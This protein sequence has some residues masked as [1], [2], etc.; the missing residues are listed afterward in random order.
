MIGESVVLSETFDIPG[1]VLEHR[2][3]LT[4][5]NDLI[6]GVATDPSDPD[7]LHMYF[8]TYMLHSAPLAINIYSNI[9][10]KRM[11]LP[12]WISTTNH[13]LQHPY[14][15]NVLFDD[16]PQA[17]DACASLII[18]GFSVL[19]SYPI[20]IPLQ[21][22]L[23][24]FKHL[25]LM[26]GVSSLTYWLAV[27]VWDVTKL[28]FSLVL[29]HSFVFIYPVSSAASGGF[30]STKIATLYI[31]FAYAYSI[32]MLMY[33]I[34]HFAHSVS[35]G[36]ALSVCLTVLFGV[37][38]P[39]FTLSA[40]IGTKFITDTATYSLLFIP[41]F[42]AASAIR[43]YFVTQL[44]IQR[45]NHF[46]DIGN[47]YFCTNETAKEEPRLGRLSCCLNCF[48]IIEP[49]H[50][51]DR[52]E[53]FNTLWTHQPNEKEIT[54]SSHLP[55]ISTSSIFWELSAMIF[56]GFIFNFLVVF[57]DSDLWSTVGSC[58]FGMRGS[59]FQTDV[60]DEDVVD[61]MDRVDEL[62]RDN[63]V[64]EE[65]LVMH[66]LCKSFGTFPAVH[67]IS[68]GIHPG[69]CFGILGVNGA[70]KSTLF[71]LLSSSILESYGN[72]YSENCSLTRGRIQLLRRLGYS[73]FHGKAMLGYMTP[74]EHLWLFSVLRGLPSAEAK[75]EISDI[76]TNLS[77]DNF[78]D[79]F[80]WHSYFKLVVTFHHALL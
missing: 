80:N 44:S 51:F 79:F 54:H 73:P 13:P 33:T 61:E 19:L 77:S 8:S 48:D 29:A 75:K 62:V 9:I 18:I 30:N 34:S 47:Q 45:C 3:Y 38:V 28:L 60:E 70:G 6:L 1:D 50:C 24:D 5:R 21:E 72:V 49:I 16:D 39:I 41:M 42:A 67:N 11:S 64:S 43:K 31:L 32:L 69:E 65:S 71:R 55:L 20:I 57:L 78:N 27:F 36:F 14:Y 68:V 37:I 23:N 52:T 26:S 74:K 56:V 2:D 63:R 25:Q 59:A 66:N 4:L 17:E 10:M 22:R 12:G 53:M 7:R 58:V 76:M 35:G 15:H 46:T 40:T